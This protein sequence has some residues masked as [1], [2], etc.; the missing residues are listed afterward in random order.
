MMKTTALL[1]LLGILILSSCVK[2][3]DQV[4]DNRLTDAEKQEG[5]QLLFDGKTLS[6]WR[7]FNQNDVPANWTVEDGCLKGTV[8]D[9]LMYGKEEF[10]NFELTVQWKLTK[11]AN[12]GIFYHVQEGAQ[13]AAPYENG[14]EY[15]VIDDLG[16]PEPLQPWQ[17]AGADYAMYPPDSSKPVKPA[18]EWNVSRI[19]FTPEKAE[20]WLNGVLTATFV[21][22]SDDWNARRAAGKWKDY[23]DY[24]KAAT[25]LIG[26]Q[27]ESGVVLYKNIKIRTLP[28]Q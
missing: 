20:Y 4:A 16:W 26:F 23:P 15:Q 12:S 19:R 28:P 25:G 11:G 13:Y 3:T 7:G 9:Y 22:W 6:G 27:N 1:A 14:P 17:T 5:W 8:G 10:E 21:P 18:G 2:D 24:G